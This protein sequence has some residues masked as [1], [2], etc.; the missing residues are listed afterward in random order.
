MIDLER[1]GLPGTLVVEG[2]EVPVDTSFRAW[3]RFS[4]LLGEGVAWP[5]VFPGGEP[6]GEWLPAALEFLA[7][8][9]PI[10]RATGEGG[11]RID[12]TADSDWLVAAFMQA[13]GIDLTACD[14]HWHLFLALVRGLPA[15]TRL[16][17][18]LGHR[19]WRRD[20]RKADAIHEELRA[21]WT[22]PDGETDDEVLDL[23]RQW[24]G[25]VG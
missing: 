11:S 6:A 2:A 12:W 23:Q 20:G 1:R 4:R 16:S 17:E 18:V 14:M 19:A 21:M 9:N 22:V 8:E 7:S 15:S 25:G 13:Y 5:G 3:L 24:F 10:P